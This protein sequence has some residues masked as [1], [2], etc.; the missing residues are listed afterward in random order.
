MLLSILLLNSAQYFTKESKAL[1]QESLDSFLTDADSLN[2]SI[3]S[4][5]YI[6]WDTM[7]PLIKALYPPNQ[8][9]LDDRLCN[10]CKQ[11]V[12]LALQTM[13]QRDYHCA[14]LMNEEVVDYILCLLWYSSGDV[15]DRAESLVK[16]VRDDPNVDYQP[17]SLVN[18]CK[19]AVAVHYCGLET[20]MSL[21]VPRLADRIMFS[22]R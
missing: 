1:A 4:D 17:P 15:K 22:A 9:S 14:I 21:S 18:M 11:T 5:Y 6:K 7:T 12:L 8:P 10:A 2:P 16:M 3:E 20:V 13:L 19:A